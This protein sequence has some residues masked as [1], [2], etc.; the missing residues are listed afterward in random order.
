[1]IELAP[2]AGDPDSLAHGVNGLGLVAGNSGAACGFKRAALWE[3]GMVIDL[4]NPFG[5]FKAS[6]IG[7]ELGPEGLEAYTE[8][9]T[10]VL[11]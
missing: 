7:R 1:M 2:V 9:Q 11:G 8:I 6:G 5:G 10:I 3:N 4:K